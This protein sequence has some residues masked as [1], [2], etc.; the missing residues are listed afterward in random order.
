MPYR[1]SA[2]GAGNADAKGDPMFT[3]QL[4]RVE[5]ARDREKQTSPGRLPHQRAARMMDQEDRLGSL[6]TGF[7]AMLEPPES[8]AALAARRSSSDCPT[9]E[10][11]LR[12]M[13]G[14]QGDSRP[15]GRLFKI[16]ALDLLEVMECGPSPHGY[17]VWGIAL[18]QLVV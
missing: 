8:N 14:L 11:Y 12:V 7:P 9:Y 16:D 10:A 2:G 5:H 3:P 15:S 18:I 6:Q 13:G 17:L 1:L 4:S